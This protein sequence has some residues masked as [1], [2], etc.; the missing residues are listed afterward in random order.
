MHK[1]WEHTHRQPFQMSRTFP[2][3]ERPT[4]KQTEYNVYTHLL[5]QAPRPITVYISHHQQSNQSTNQNLRTS[6]LRSITAT[7]CN[8]TSS[9]DIKAISAQLVALI[10]PIESSKLKVKDTLYSYDSFDILPLLLNNHK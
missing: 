5:T 10:L 3:K 4:V 1:L 8:H 7:S 2:R 6:Q 9:P